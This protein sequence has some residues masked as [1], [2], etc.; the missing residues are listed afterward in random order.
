MRNRKVVPRDPSPEMQAKIRRAVEAV[1]NQPRRVIKCPYCSH[2]GLIVFADA[3][4][5]VQTKCKL[6]DREVIL[7]VVNMRRPRHNRVVTR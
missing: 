6:C 7:D 3:T 4:G 5:H 1:R 2:S